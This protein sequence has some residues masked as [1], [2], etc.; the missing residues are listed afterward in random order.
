[1]HKVHQRLLSGLLCLA[2]VAGFVPTIAAADNGEVPAETEAALI[3]T[4]E[5]VIE[6]TQAATV[7]TTE[8]VL[9]ETEAATVE[10]AA[11][12]EEQSETTTAEE[13]APAETIAEATEPAETV[14]VEENT[15]SLAESG[16]ISSGTPDGTPPVLVSLELEKTTVTAPG[17]IAVT[18]EATDDVSGVSHISVWFECEET[19]K[20]LHGYLESIYWDDESGEYVPY[21]DG[22]FHG[23]ITV[24]QYLESGVFTLISIDVA[25][26]AGNYR[27]YYN[28]YNADYPSNHAPIPEELKNLQITVVEGVNPDGTPPVLESLELEKTTV[29]APG[30]IAV[31]AEATDDV[32]GVSHISVWFECEETGKSLHGYLESIYWDDESGE[33]VPYADGKFHGTITVDQYLESGV[34]TLISIDVAD[35]AGNY[36]YYYNYYNADYPSNHAPIPEQLQSLTIQVINAL[37]DVTTS[38]AKPEFVEE[39][40]NAEE[41]AYIVA[42]YSGNA[43]VPE[44]V[45]DAISGTDKTLDLVSEGITWRFEGKD[46]V[47][48]AKDIDL[49]VEIKPVEQ[50]T[51]ETGKDIQDA[52][53]E[54]PAVVMKFPENGTLPGK[55]T[56]QV[57]VDY[58]MQQ[59]LGT[60]RKLSVYYFNNQTGKLELI[61]GNLTV[62]GDS[63]V[64]F[65]ITHCS[66]YILTVEPAAEKTEVIPVYRLYNPYTQEHLLTGGAEERD[67]LI[68][69]GW[70]LDGVAWEAPVDGI[71]VYRLY[72]PYD[73]W[74]TYTTSESERDTMVAAGWKVDGVVS[75]SYTGKDGRPIYRLFNPY[76]KTNFHLITA[77]V[78]ERDM[79]VN[80]GWIL[81]GVAWHA[82]K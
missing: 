53:E 21:A 60:N 41:D 73:D 28:Y 62:N 74:H 15:D 82:V 50:D 78:E 61:A 12:I 17:T 46:I 48:D 19:G 72:N 2:M 81:E 43:T 42:D 16:D 34:F 67:A 20:S 11:E 56:I 36:R 27:Y 59:Y 8:V 75:F 63:Y 26:E 69:V 39:V 10:T 14:V 32:S 76:V 18:A 1:M 44:D 6:E 80:A 64:E 52:L 45:F 33:Y 49:H 22:K 55:A 35:E 79:L 13:T 58:T 38:V 25:D 66:Y 68:S 7:E 77:G 47:N 9:G 24:D 65:P 40:R 4:V 5:A 29:T 31:T 23:T 3:E 71:S 30:T 70:S 51:S 57:K 37:P 54:A